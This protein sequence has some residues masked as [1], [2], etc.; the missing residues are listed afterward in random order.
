MKHINAIILLTGMIFINLNSEAQEAEIIIANWEDVIPVPGPGPGVWQYFTSSG[1]SEII[2]NPVPDDINS[3]EKVLAYY[4]SSGEWLLTGFYYMDGIPITKKLTGIEFKIY[5]ENLVKCYVKLIGIVDGVEDSTIIENAWPWTVPSGAKVW[6]T[7]LLQIDGNA[8]LN[9]TVT[10]L[11]I[12]PNPQ[13]PEAAQD[14]F[15]IDEVRFL[16]T[17][18]V[19]SIILNINDTILELD[20][21]IYLEATIYPYDASNQN[22]SWISMNTS[23]ATVSSIGKVQARG[24]GST[25][26]IVKTEDGDKT[27]TC[28]ITVTDVDGILE[29]D[30]KLLRIYPNPY[31]N[32]E[33]VIIL[34]ESSNA[35]IYLTIYNILGET[36]LTSSIPE[37]GN[38]ISILP[39]LHNGIYLIKVKTRG[40]IWYGRII[41]T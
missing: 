8:L 29:T 25:S 9:D 13:L 3:T 31:Q 36:I 38:R 5:G 18:P 39:E 10:T 12:F 11:L 16:L 28:L 14:T 2:T 4:R 37:T 21:S 20:E 30:A 34:P 19:D 32:G 27:D 26:I 40:N 15:Y 1:A 41:K 23:I 7:I 17:V 22:F 35:D 33:L 24:P 6:N